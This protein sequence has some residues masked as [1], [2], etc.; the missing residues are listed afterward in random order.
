MYI[1]IF[2]G[3][4]DPATYEDVTAVLAQGPWHL[5]QQPGF[6]GFQESGYDR[7]NGRFVG[8]STWDTEHAG[9]SP[10]ALLGDKFTRLEALGVQMELEV[11][12]TYT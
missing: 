8:V 10:A 2:R 9:F 12:A 1:R 6:Q 4:F 3:R 11:Y 5:G 7:A